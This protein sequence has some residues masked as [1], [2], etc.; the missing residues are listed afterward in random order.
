MRCS[1]V[2]RV[3]EAER[4]T[5][6]RI[7]TLSVRPPCCHRPTVTR[8]GCNLCGVET[9][10]SEQEHTPSPQPTRS[11]SISVGRLPL[12]SSSLSAAKA[13]KRRSCSSNRW[14]FFRAITSPIV[15]ERCKLGPRSRFSCASSACSLSVSMCALIGASFLQG[16]SSAGAAAPAGS[17]LQEGRE[18]MAAGLSWQLSS[19]R[20][21]RLCDEAAN[22]Q[23]LD[24]QC[25]TSVKSC[26]QGLARQHLVTKQRRRHSAD[27]LGWRLL[28]PLRQEPATSSLQAGSRID[29]DLCPSPTVL[30]HRVQRPQ[31][32]D[33]RQPDS[34]LRHALYFC[35]N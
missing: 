19:Q 32:L 12:P 35:K 5:S 9:S 27:A 7:L 2:C 10:R 8:K 23:T 13:P 6:Y 28:A 29:P 15:G 18:S 17:D 1:F 16:S 26:R 21:R 30:L 3:L 25:L 4:R 22:V 33:P 11:C 31:T 14:R 20:T 24:A 34:S